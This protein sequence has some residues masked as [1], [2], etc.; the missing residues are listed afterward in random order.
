MEHSW[1]V[2]KSSGMVHSVEEESWRTREG[3]NQSY[4]SC[5]LIKNKDAL[6]PIGGFLPG[7]K[8][9]T[10]CAYGWK[11][12]DSSLTDLKHLLQATKSGSHLET[13]ILDKIKEKE[14]SEEI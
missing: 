12:S 13:L 10:K 5:G 7:K 14:E 3:D 6:E 11:L 1:V 8:L 4:L 9:C 2:L